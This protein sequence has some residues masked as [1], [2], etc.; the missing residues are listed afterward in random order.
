MRYIIS[1][2]ISLPL[3]TSLSANATTIYKWVDKNGVTHYSQQQPQQGEAEKLYSE[4]IEQAP[5]GF[6]SPKVPEE[7]TQQDE[8]TVAAETITR[9]DQAQAKAICD[10]AKH[11]LNLLQTSARLRK[12]DPETG[13]IE[14]MTDEQ[15]QA[16]IANQQKRIKLFCQ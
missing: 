3:L 2:L 10:S 9:Q 4:D 7:V 5:I 11:Q 6:E 1:V 12:K 15:K 8:L 14:M 16:E 13:E